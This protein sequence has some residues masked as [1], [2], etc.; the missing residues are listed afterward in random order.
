MASESVSSGSKTSG[1]NSEASGTKPD[2]KPAGKTDSSSPADVAVPAALAAIAQ[3]ISKLQQSIDGKIM[4]AFG[5]QN[6]LSLRVAEMV[7]NIDK[8]LVGAGTGKAV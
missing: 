8:N 7:E 4:S 6:S 5:K 3:R 1:S 2:S